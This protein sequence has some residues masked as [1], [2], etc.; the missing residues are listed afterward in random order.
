MSCTLCTI[1]RGFGAAFIIFAII[2]LIYLLIYGLIWDCWLREHWIFVEARKRKNTREM[3]RLEG[4]LWD[5]FAGKDW[6]KGM[7]IR[8]TALE[9]KKK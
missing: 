1:A 7:E 8:I 6:V 9:K 4:I 5:S 2:G 3:R